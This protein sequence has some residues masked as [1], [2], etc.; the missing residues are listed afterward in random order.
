M[1]GK[2]RK[3]VEATLG[4]VPKGCARIWIGNEPWHVRA[5]ETAMACHQP[6]TNESFGLVIGNLDMSDPIAVKKAILAKAQ[7]L[8]R[9]KTKEVDIQQPL[10]TT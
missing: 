8:T 5:G 1:S 6:L 2:N 7:E 4:R 3:D 9:R 10:L